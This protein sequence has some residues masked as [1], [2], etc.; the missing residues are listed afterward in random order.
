MRAAHAAVHAADFAALSEADQ[1]ERLVAASGAGRANI[2]RYCSLNLY[3]LGRLGTLEFRRFHGTLDAALLIRWAHFCV[4]FVDA[5]AAAPW[6]PIED[7]RTA[8]EALDELAAAQ[9]AATPEELMQRMRGHVDPE[10]S[11][12]FMRAALGG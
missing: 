12:Y 6:S 5:F 3:A 11:D 4:A 2:G 8:D 7:C 9:E 1:V 10:T